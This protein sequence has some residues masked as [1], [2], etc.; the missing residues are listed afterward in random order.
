M[1]GEECFGSLLNRPSKL[2]KFTFVF[3]QKSNVCESTSAI[4]PK[5]SKPANFFG[6]QTK[7]VS[8][9][10]SAIGWFEPLAIKV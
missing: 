6:H 3:V 2:R 5:I 9:T 8:Q 1:R 10:F 4:D 7:T